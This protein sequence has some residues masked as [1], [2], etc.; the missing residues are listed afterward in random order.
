MIMKCRNSEA[1]EMKD[2]ELVFQVVITGDSIAPEAMK[3]LSGK[4]RVDFAGPYPN[5]AELAQKLSRLKA[6][7][8]IVRTGRI[9]GEVIKA[10]PQLKV[11]AKHGI[12]VDTIDV[13]A[14]SELKIPV[15]VASSANYESV[16]E[17]TLGLMLC[18]AK[19]IPWLDSRIRQG[20][21]D[22]TTYRG[23]ELFQKTLGLVGFGR[24]GRRVREL[25]APLRMEIL[26]YDPMIPEKDFPEGVTRVGKLE[27]LLRK[28]DIVSLH[29]PL[30]EQTRHLIG[31]KELGMMKK[32]AWLV[33]TARG[34]VVDGEALVRALREEKIAAA[35]IDTFPQEPPKDLRSLGNAGK[36]VLTPHIAAATEESFNRMG[37]EAAKNVLAILQGEIPEGDRVVNPEV[38]RRPK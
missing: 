13:K 27:T 12:G 6:D 10:S 36:V 15:L 24:I 18:L 20:Y 8:L 5:P 26:V 34:E 7:A 37:V 31:E 32:T 14:A 33:N 1:N 21:W 29:C 23:R 28:A 19:D 3:L 25:V 35:A 22:K 11:I 38:L 4:C 30:T 16:A 9:P 2:P 17:H